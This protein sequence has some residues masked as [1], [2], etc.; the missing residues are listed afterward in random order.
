MIDLNPSPNISIIVAQ[1]Q[2][3]AIG[4]DN[5]LL[6]HIS[7]DLRRFKALTSGHSVIMGRRTFM[8]LPRRPLPNRRNI[9][10]THDQGF[11]YPLPPEATATL[12]V[13]HS[14]PAALKMVAGEEEA[15]VIG[16]AEVYRSFLPLATRLYVTWVYADFEADAYFP[17]I[18]LSAF[19]QTALSGRTTDHATGLEYAYAEYFRTM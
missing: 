2:N 8:S 19:R 13:A 16:G 15:F 18:D 17:V 1:A 3:R 11:N 10:L 9:V 7:D 6:W 5:N 4:K 14:I 12:E